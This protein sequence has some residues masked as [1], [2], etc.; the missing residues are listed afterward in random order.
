MKSP[1]P[2]EKEC[3]GILLDRYS[4]VNDIEEKGYKDPREKLAVELGYGVEQVI[5][6]RILAKAANQPPIK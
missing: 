5:E 4:F 1:I 2:E 3:W 6:D